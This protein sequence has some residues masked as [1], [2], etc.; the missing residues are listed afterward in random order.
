M[1]VIS[2]E[3]TRIQ[4]G[5]V[6]SAIGGIVALTYWI[7][8]VSFTASA[9]EVKNKEQDI[10]QNAQTIILLDMKEDLVAIKTVLK[11]RRQR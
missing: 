2:A 5:L 9:A 3:K 11:L 1:S 4:L 10:A 6:V 7:S 8:S